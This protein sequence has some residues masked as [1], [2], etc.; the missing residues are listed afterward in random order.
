M[1]ISE[2]SATI[3]DIAEHHIRALALRKKGH[4]TRL[5]LSW[6]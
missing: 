6:A 5:E 2:T 1:S 3:L 4:S